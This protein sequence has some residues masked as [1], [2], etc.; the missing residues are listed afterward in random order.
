MFIDL[1]LTNM[2]SHSLENCLA[3]PLTLIIWRTEVRREEA[4]NIPERHFEI[5]HLIYQ[6][7]LVERTHILMTPAVRSYLCKS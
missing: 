7:C 1:T 4:Q 6:L 5:M 3:S 2:V